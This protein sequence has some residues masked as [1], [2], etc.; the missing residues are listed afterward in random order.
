MT[1]PRKVADMEVAA[2]TLGV[3]VR[4]NS[5]AVVGLIQGPSKNLVCHPRAVGAD[6]EALDPLV[7]EGGRATGTAICVAT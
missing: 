1:I 5:A 3:V 7:A 2:T 4:A 6:K